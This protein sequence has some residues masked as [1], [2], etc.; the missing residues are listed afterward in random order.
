MGY[1]RNVTSCA[2]AVVLA[3]VVV[4]LAPAA[5]HA[6]SLDPGAAPWTQVPRERV[7]EECGLDPNLLEAADALFPTSSYT[8]VRYGKLCWTGGSGPSPTQSYAV[9]SVTKTFGALLVGMVA[10]RSSLSDTDLVA[11]WLAPGQMGTTNPTATVA[12]VLATTSTKASLA[13]DEKGAWTYDTFGTR[14]INRLISV[15]NAVIAAEPENF[16]GISN[17][18]QF[19]QQELFNVL[20][21]TSSSWPSGG[22]GFGLQT[23]VYD[24]SRM[25]LLLLRKGN[26]NGQQLIDEDYVYRM[27]HPGFA[28]TNSGYGYLTWLNAHTLTGGGAGT[29]AENSCTPYA[30]W[31]EYPHAPFY[32]TLHDYG[33]SPFG[34][35]IHDVG[36]AFA[37]G[38]GGQFTQVHRAFD[39]VLS[40]RNLPGAYALWHAIR[41]ALV[42]LDP[43]FQG[44]P[45]GFC[46]EY[47][48][49]MY[50]PTMLS[51]WDPNIGQVIQRLAQTR[52]F[53]AQFDCGPHGTAVRALATGAAQCVRPAGYDVITA[54]RCRDE[55]NGHWRRDGSTAIC[56]T[57]DAVITTALSDYIQTGTS[58]TSRWRARIQTTTT[59]LYEVADSQQGALGAKGTSGT[60]EQ[61]REVIHVDVTHEVAV[62]QQGGLLTTTW[63]TRSLDSPQCLAIREDFAAAD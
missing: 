55:L 30:T 27:T 24:M 8:V 45:V 44:D 17:A 7:A 40:G 5:V 50:A 31:N 29:I 42:E 23:S 37:A 19:A 39:L 25:G 52:D 11:D 35:Q 51:S 32:E 59:T 20:G 22:L 12:H 54:A 43:V 41:P 13:V 1:L 14:E 36:V 38:L 47:R 46:A 60:Y 49:G 9:Q 61:A 34:Q 62:C 53:G 33:G 63:N 10:A 6:G 58:G 15:M 16:P 4:G 3:S 57:D 28:D 2:A 18:Y 26:W 56:T 21:M 48:R